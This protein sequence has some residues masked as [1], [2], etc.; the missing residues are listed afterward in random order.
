MMAA[1]LGLAFLVQTFLRHGA[2]V[3]ACDLDGNTPLH[4]AY[5]Y[6]HM[7]VI[8]LLEDKNSDTLKKNIYGSRPDQIMGMKGQGLYG[9]RAL[10]KC[11][12]KTRTPVG[13]V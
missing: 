7:S 1:G 9:N 6:A 2:D 11:L 4:Y 10:Q 3:N 12:I 8:Q 5:S 13:T